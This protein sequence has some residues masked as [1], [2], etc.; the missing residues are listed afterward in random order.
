[1]TA[2]D[3]RRRPTPGRR[4][5][6]GMPTVIVD[7]KPRRPSRFV[8]ILVG[9]A[10]GIAC[11][12]VLVIAAVQ[13]RGEIDSAQIADCREGNVPNA[14][15][16][17]KASRYHLDR[18]GSPAARDVLPILWCAETARQGRSVRLRPDVEARYLRIFRAGRLPHIDPDTGEV[19]GSEPFPAP[20]PPHRRRR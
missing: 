5:H 4:G 16:R 18:D 3:E 1:M 13:R 15:L 12:A 19:D 11:A 10:I 2:E 9:A 6:D 8:L 7:A 17:I 14:Y 20:A